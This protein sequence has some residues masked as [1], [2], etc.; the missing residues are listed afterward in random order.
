MLGSTLSKEQWHEIKRYFSSDG[1][2]GLKV[3]SSA[4]DIMLTAIVP[5]KSTSIIIPKSEA[6]RLFSDLLIDLGSKEAQDKLVLDIL[7]KRAGV[8]KVDLL[9]EYKA[10]LNEFVQVMPKITRL[11][12][13]NRTYK[14][15]ETWIFVKKV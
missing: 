6:H 1:K 15:P 8:S 7:M 3:F 2:A 4:D 12:D 11:K 14:R 5:G 13:F 9:D 10:V